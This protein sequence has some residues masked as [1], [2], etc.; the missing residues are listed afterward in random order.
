MAGALRLW[1]SVALLVVVAGCY[2]EGLPADA[3]G[4]DGEM[5]WT[6]AACERHATAAAF[7]IGSGYECRQ[8]VLGVTRTSTRYLDG[9]PVE[10]TAAPRP[11]YLLYRTS[12]TDNR[13]YIATFDAPGNQTPGHNLDICERARQ[14]FQKQRGGSESYWCEPAR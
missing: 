12:L 13:V 3:G 5:F 10:L 9:V 4:A 11:A 6:S 8:K 14:L 7:E 2:T 1:S